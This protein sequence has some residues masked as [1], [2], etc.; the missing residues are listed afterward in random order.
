MEGAIGSGGS[1]MTT[2]DLEIC[3]MSFF[4]IRHN[5]IVPNISWGIANLHE[6]DL[7]VLSRSNY[8]TEVEIKISRADLLKDKK[9][10]H[11]HKHNHIARLY[12]AVPEKLVELALDEIPSRAGLIVCK[13][14]TCKNGSTI[15]AKKIR[16][17]KRN[18]KAH[19][20]S[21]KEKVKLCHLGTMR[22]LGLKKKISKLL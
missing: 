10:K 16:E 12:Y 20:W 14:I 13:E 8:A 7:L 9:K 18:M 11:G 21:E 19:Q 22:I 17:C 5:I 1:H 6:C 3:L 15:Y 2:L 4:N